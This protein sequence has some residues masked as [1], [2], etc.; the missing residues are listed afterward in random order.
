MGARNAEVRSAGVGGRTLAI[1]DVHG[2]LVALD[3]L[4]AAL[5]LRPGD[6]LVFVGDYVNGGL[7]SAGVLDRISGLVA[8][9][10]A[11]ALRGNHDDMFL[12]ALQYPQRR[13]GFLAIGG[14]STLDSYPDSSFDSVP[15][16]HQ[17]FLRDGLVNAFQTESHI[18]VHAGVVR[19]LPVDQQPREVL[20]WQRVQ[21]SAGHAS[22]KVVVCGHSSQKSTEVLDLGHT[23][24]IDTNIKGGG[25]L[26]CL[27]VGSG[28]I[29]QADE[30]GRL[31]ERRLS[32]G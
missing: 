15:P 26:T 28:A 22:G 20:L 8:D 5:N 31:R 17:R 13:E 29:V 19:D 7:D 10:G 1:G 27:D 12:S 6:R 18:F 11:V 3:A 9:R 30:R 24:C 32:P 25:W 2:H 23:I 14:Q 16:E 4:L 21:S